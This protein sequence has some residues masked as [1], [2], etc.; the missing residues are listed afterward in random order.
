ME[1]G[2]P[3]GLTPVVKGGLQ[4]GFINAEHV[5]RIMCVDGKPSIG[6]S[7]RTYTRRLTETGM[8]GLTECINL[9]ND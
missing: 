4:V 9:E 3:I 6:M 1:S 7:G 5:S 2:N 8:Q